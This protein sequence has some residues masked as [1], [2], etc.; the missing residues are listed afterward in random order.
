M[1]LGADGLAQAGPSLSAS[2]I[3][4]PPPDLGR[5]V[6]LHRRN[7]RDSGAAAL[8]RAGRPS[9]AVGFSLLATTRCPFRGAKTGV[10]DSRDR[11]ECVVAAI[12]RRDEPEA[13]VDIKSF[14]GAGGHDVLD[15]TAP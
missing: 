11:R 5:R 15:Y 9:A 3:G 6:S 12:L 7:T 8:L 13:I 1:S 10:L 4:W 2:L 14:Y